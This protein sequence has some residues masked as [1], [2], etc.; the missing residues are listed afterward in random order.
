MATSDGLTY[1]RCRA[2]PTQRVHA[3]ARGI[4]RARRLAQF[5]AEREMNPLGPDIAMAKPAGNSMDSTR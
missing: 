5:D 3:D 4:D 1:A 2:V